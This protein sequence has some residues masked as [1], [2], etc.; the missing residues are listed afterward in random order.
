MIGI[1]G[2][3]EKDGSGVVLRVWDSDRQNFTVSEALVCDASFLANPVK[4]P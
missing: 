2:R 3:P 4:G 1:G